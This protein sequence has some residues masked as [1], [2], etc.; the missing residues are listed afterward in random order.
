MHAASVAA[1]ECVVAL[2]AVDG[3]DVNT[4]NKVRRGVAWCNEH[5]CTRTRT[6][7]LLRL[8]FCVVHPCESE[9]NRLTHRV[10]RTVF[11]ACVCRVGH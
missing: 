2:L 10:R 9:P 4:Q 11:V 7:P 1:A 3:I 8:R 6:A 5:A